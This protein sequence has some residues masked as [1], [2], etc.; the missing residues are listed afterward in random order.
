MQFSDS[1]YDKIKWLVQIAFPALG[2]LYFGMAQIWGFPYG[3][4]IVG[5]FAVLALFFGTLVG[6]SH[7]NY[8]RRGEFDGEVGIDTSNVDKDRV[9]LQFNRPLEKLQGKSLVTL[10]V[11]DLVGEFPE[12]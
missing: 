6:I 7:A 1:V 12:E 8:V 9:V 5:T 10:N 11:K 4:E 2:S 3:E